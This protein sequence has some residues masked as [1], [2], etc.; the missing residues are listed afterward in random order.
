MAQKQTT[1]KVR[2]DELPINKQFSELV[3][4]IEKL[5]KPFQHMLDIGLEKRSGKYSTLTFSIKVKL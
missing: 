3:E 2:I 4:E 1:N 5:L